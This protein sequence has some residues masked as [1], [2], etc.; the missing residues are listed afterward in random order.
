MFFSFAKFSVALAVFGYSFTTAQQYAGDHVNTTLPDVPG[1]E[2]AFFKITDPTG[3][4]KN[5]M[6]LI[7][8]MSLTSTNGRPVL[9]DIERAVIVVHG[10]DRDPETYESNVRPSCGVNKSIE[11]SLMVPNRCSALFRK[12]PIRTSTLTPL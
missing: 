8:Y 12:S 6:T 9:S 3:K 7:N 4:V 5:N 1:S 10:L 2:I 11:S